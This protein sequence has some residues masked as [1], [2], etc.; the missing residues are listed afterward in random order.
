MFPSDFDDWSV[1]E[2]NKASS[3]L[4]SL[5]RPP[6]RK[7]I[8]AVTTHS[9]KRL[10]LEVF[11]DGPHGAPSSAIFNAEHAILVQNIFPFVE[12]VLLI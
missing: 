11:I 4:K 12:R 6:T 1:A 5:S 8:R 2:K 10:P 9:K 3:H 7:M